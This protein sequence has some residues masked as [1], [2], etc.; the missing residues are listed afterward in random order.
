[1]PSVESQA[2]VDLSKAIAEIR[3]SNPNLDPVLNGLILEE[4]H[5]LA[6]EPTNL[7]YEDVQCPGS[8][9]PAIWCKPLLASSS[10]VILYFHGGGFSACSPSSHRKMAGH[11]AK[12]AGCYTLLPDYRRTPEHP[13]PAQIEDAIAT[14][15]WLLKDQGISNHH[16]AT[17]GDSAGGNLAVTSVLKMRELGLPLPSAIVGLSPHVDMGEIGKSLDT[18]AQ[19]DVLVTRSSVRR[20][21]TS[22][23]RDTPRDNPLANPLHADLSGLP[24]M[25]L[26][27]GSVEM[28]RDDAVML[29]D[30]AKRADVDVELEISE[31]MQHVYTFMAG[32]APEAINTINDIGRWLKNRLQE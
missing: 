25:Y 5:R 16:I 12:A 6:S 14:Y 3:A 24:P 7:T 1:M 2:Q 13:F 26:C 29:A 15:Q 23:L 28:L 19:T 10:H 11:L 22:Y 17:A 32:K 20:M 30:R 18:N 9:R 27:A 21:T 4:W 31:G 8:V